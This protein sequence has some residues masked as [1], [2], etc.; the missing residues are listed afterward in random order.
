MIIHN[1]K[2]DIRQWFLVTS[3]QPLVIWMYKESYLRFSSQEFSLVNFHESVHLTN[4]AVQKRYKN[5]RRDE[6]LPKENM[7][8]CHTFQAYLRQI[9]K[10]DMWSER[11]YPGMQK[12]LIGTMLASQET[13][14]RRINTFEVST[15]FIR[16]CTERYLPQFFYISFMEPILWC[17]K[18]ANHG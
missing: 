11:I 17:P 13:M 5:G 18:I 3:V 12:A 2:F 9:G 4:H 14:D 6:R 1:C 8:D 10:A 7:W 15:N 16:F